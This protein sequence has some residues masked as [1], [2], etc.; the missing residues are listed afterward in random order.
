MSF[1]TEVE[2]FLLDRVYLIEIDDF[3]KRSLASREENV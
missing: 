2:L 3:F 1:V